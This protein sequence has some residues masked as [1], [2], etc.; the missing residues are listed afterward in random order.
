[1]STVNLDIVD[2]N[3]A[4]LGPD[5]WEIYRVAIVSG[6]TGTASKRM[7]D[8][9]AHADIP[10]RETA[11]PEIDGLWLDAYQ[12]DSVSNDTVKIRLVYREKYPVSQESVTE[13][14]ASLVQQQ[15]NTD[16]AGN[17]LTVSWL[18]ASS[19]VQSQSGTVSLMVPQ[20]TLLYTK[21][22]DEDPGDNAEDYVGR[23]NAGGWTLKPQAP[24]RTWLCTG[25]TGRSQ[26]GG[27]WYDVR[28]TWQKASDAKWDTKVVFRDDDGQV[29]DDI[30]DGSSDVEITLSDA[31]EGV[32]LTAS[33]HNF[34]TDTAKAQ[35][36]NVR[37][38]DGA[39]LSSPLQHG[40]TYWIQ[41]FDSTTFSLH[42]TKKGAEDNVNRVM[43][44]EAVGGG[45]HYIQIGLV[46]YQGYPEADFSGLDL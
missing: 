9:W 32:W 29:P 11:H 17:L 40:R 22:E 8:A 21:R 44:I 45:T 1:M 25:I 12:F 30:A 46:T 4:S 36:C 27:N 38:Y 19:T 37:T 43:N 13:T 5:G 6:L 14:G 23:V 34:E 7:Y 3:T 35:A 42:T 18:D 31:A 10:P 41:V 2:G 24:P 39:A 33:A 20:S 16:A 28:Y 26:D 15:A